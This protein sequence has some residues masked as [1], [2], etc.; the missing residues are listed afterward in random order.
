MGSVEKWFCESPAINIRVCEAGKL[1]CDDEE[2][3]QQRVKSLWEAAVK[4][5]HLVPRML[6][7]IMH[8]PRLLS[9][10]RFLMEL[11]G[12]P[13]TLQVDYVFFNGTALRRRVS[14]PPTFCMLLL[15][16]PASFWS[17]ATKFC[18]KV[19]I[20]FLNL[21]YRFAEVDLDSLSAALH[22]DEYV[23]LS[24]QLLLQLR[25]GRVCFLATHAAVV[26]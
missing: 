6:H 10:S 7:H 22:I 19:H 16:E 21:S 14:G 15:T 17:S 5:P 18:I 25:E 23:N 2:E 13:Q 9:Q 8:S 11:L 1:E 24:F 12:Q 4:N 26:H 3:H 20:L